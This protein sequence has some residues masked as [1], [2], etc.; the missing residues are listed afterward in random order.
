MRAN[1][2]AFHQAQKEFGFGVPTP[3][4]TKSALEVSDEERD[5]TFEGAW[6]SGSLVNLLTVYADLSVDQEADDTAKRFIH[7]KIH[8]IV[9]DPRASA[10]STPWAPS[11]LAWT[12]AT[13][14]QASAPA[15]R[16][17]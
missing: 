15:F 14:M 12:P 5:A 1:F 2:R 6:E 10:P 16:L 13:G 4:A 3:I 7:G 8:Q 17:G 11:A 9:E